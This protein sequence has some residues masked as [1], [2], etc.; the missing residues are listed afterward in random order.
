MERNT[1]LEEQ[2]NRIYRYCYFKLQSRERAEDV[3]QETFLRFLES[4]HYRD[5]GKAIRYLYIIARNLCM[6]EFSRRNRETVLTEQ[7]E[8]LPENCA[9]KSRQWEQSSCYDKVVI[10]VTLK[11]AL[12]QLSEENRE[13]LL[14][15]Y[16]NETPIS[17]IAHVMGISRFAVYRR[18][19][20]ALDCLREK[21]GEEEF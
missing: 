14:L 18:I 15:R 17:V 7:E 2:Y 21:L 6:D 4:K 19:R 20:A 16:V 1:D 11:E 8:G 3:T 9:E 12:L 5:T 13:L 10:K